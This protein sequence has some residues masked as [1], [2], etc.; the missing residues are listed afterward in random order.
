[1]EIN[2]YSKTG[3][4]V[5][6]TQA[7]IDPLETI[8]QGQ[9]IYLFPANATKKTPPTVAENKKAKWNG[10]AWSLVDD[11]RGSV[12]YLPTGEKITIT[13]LNKK[14]P[15]GALLIPPEV[16]PEIPSMPEDLAEIW[17]AIGI[18]KM[19]LETKKKYDVLK[20]NK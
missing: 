14:V 9:A 7:K 15:A 17:E 2:H 6:T 1:M 12:Y 13:Q 10:T 20:G 16:E 5:G 4:Y 19:S 8:R 3:E 18:E 11:Y